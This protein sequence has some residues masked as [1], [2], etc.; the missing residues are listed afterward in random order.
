MLIAGLEGYLCICEVKRRTEIRQLLLVQFG[1]YAQY[2]AIVVVQT[3]LYA[4]V[5]GFFGYI[6]AD[7]TGLLKPFILEKK[8]LAV[9]GIVTLVCGVV[10]G[11]DYWIFGTHIPEVA[12]SCQNITYSNVIASV[13]YGG[14]IEEVM[15]RLFLMS[16]IAF[17]LWKLF[18][19]ALPREKIPVK[20]FI[21][22]NV[23]AALLFAV[24]H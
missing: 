18:Y 16:L 24:G 19:R 6:L 8:K 17:S 21:I 20:V 23:I 12:D 5:C 22:A 7:K 10:F 13:L 14:I 15:M 1:G 2:L 3:M 11:L 9:S 4:A